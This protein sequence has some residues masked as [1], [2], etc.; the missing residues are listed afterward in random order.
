MIVNSYKS[1]LRKIPNITVRE[2]RIF[3]SKQLGIGQRTV[4]NVISEYNSKKTV[5]SPS[6]T[7]IKPSFKDKFDD[8][9]LNTVR[10]HVHS[11]WY[12]KTIPT[13]DKI[14]QVVKDDDSLPDI[15]RMNLQRLLKF[16]DFEY[17]K[18]SRNSALIEKDEIVVWRRRYLRA[19]RKY[20]NTVKGGQY[21]T[22]MKHGSTQETVQLKRGQ[23][24]QLN[25]PVMRF[26][27]V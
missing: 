7:R 26:Y 15:S 18:R 19:I 1:E 4:S 25:H 20:V 6:K 24:K 11:F 5:T 9:Q 16:M 3:I 8:V 2:A 14:L 12:E 22:S 21:T 23:T 10:R 13:L 17:T 27:K